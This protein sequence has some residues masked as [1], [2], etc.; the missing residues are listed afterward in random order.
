MLTTEPAVSGT[1]DTAREPGGAKQR[2]TRATAFR[3]VDLDAVPAVDA[4]LDAIGAGPFLRDTVTAPVGRNQAWLGRTSG[5]RDVFVKRL[6]GPAPDVRARMARL[7]SFE[8]F[9][10]DVPRLRAGVPVMLGHDEAENLVAFERIEARGGAE[11]MVDETFG[12]DLAESVGRTVGMLHAAGTTRPLDSSTPSLPDVSILHGM[13][14][15]L[16]N[17]LSHAELEAWRLM[18]NDT[19]LVEAIERLQRQEADAPRVPTHCDLRVD[20]LLV[21]EDGTPVLTDWEEFRAGDA[22]RDVGSFAGEWLYR[23]VLDIVTHRGA[24]GSAFTE[25]ELTHEQVLQRGAARMERLLPLVHRFWAG[26]RTV[27]RSLDPDFAARAT[28]FAGWHLLDRLIAGAAQG[29]RL[30]GIERAAAGV[31]RRALLTPDR[32]AH[33]LGFEDAS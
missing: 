9:V 19:P 7:L 4:L 29:Q 10:R 8:E 25:L 17:S 32:F 13:P 5:G 16:Y 26:Y 12:G 20:Q 31:G 22:A 11:L 6:V 28:A 3:P 33:I 27:P 15:G 18:Q 2:A 30:S 1:P 14:I 21:R 24:P 23:S